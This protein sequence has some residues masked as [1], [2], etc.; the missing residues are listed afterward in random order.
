MKKQYFLMAA[1][2]TAMAFTACSNEDEMPA[3]DNGSMNIE[4]DAM[5]EIAISN[6]GTGST[7]AARP[8]TS[9]E[10]ANNVNKVQ[11]VFFDAEGNKVTTGQGGLTFD[12]AET[13]SDYSISENGLITY[14]N[15]ESSTG[16]G[17]TNRETQKAKIRVN[18]LDENAEYTIVAYGWNGN[19][20]PYGTIS[21][22]VTDQMYYSTGESHNK[23]GIGLEEVFAGTTKAT[24][25][26]EV[27]KTEGQTT[28][29]YIKFTSQVRVE[30]TRQIAGMVAYFKNVP[31]EIDGKKVNKIT[32][33]AI[34]QS[35]GFY[36]PAALYTT[37]ESGITGNEFNGTSNSGTSETLLTFSID[38]ETQTK[39]LEDGGKIYL[40][41]NDKEDGKKFQVADEMKTVDVDALKLQDNTLFGGRFILPFAKHVGSKTGWGSTL[42]VKIFTEGNSEAAAKTLTVKTNDAPTTPTTESALELFYDIRCNN[43]YSIGEKMD[44]D[45]NTPGGGDNP[46]DLSAED[47]L[48]VLVN[49]AWSVIHDMDLL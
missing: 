24:T 35:K 5:I 44:T 31:A 39:D 21:N 2:A 23:S 47:N 15:T 41:G 4:P 32:V 42:L 7:R 8:V 45:N 28:V 29:T 3:V 18:G 16:P 25:S 22:P 40:F 27:S 26:K 20:F 10:A 13:T 17:E 11:Q 14:T 6:T 34:D 37:T 9:S 36:F 19:D 33:E 43:F 38:T 1:F 30:L 12:E 48:M 49:D 46:A